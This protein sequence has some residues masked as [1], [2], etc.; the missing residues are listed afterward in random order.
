MPESIV[1]RRVG[2]CALDDVGVQID[3]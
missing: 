2:R 1:T 3:L